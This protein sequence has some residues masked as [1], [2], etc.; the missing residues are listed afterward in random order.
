MTEY[1]TI[2]DAAAA[3]RSGEVTSVELV[4][5]AGTVS[6]ALD[7]KLGMF[8]KRFQDT[9][10]AAATEV[11]K[12]LAAGEAVGPLAGIPLGIKDIIMTTEA[13]ATAQSLVLDPAWSEGDAVVV[14]RLRAAGGIV[15]GKLT[16]CEFA[17]GM[18]DE[19][20]PFPIPRNPW[21]LDRWAGGSSSGSGSSVAVGSVLGALGTDTGGSIRLPAAYCGITGL[22]Q[23]FGRVPK[24]GCAPLGYTLDHIGPMARSAR[25]C[26]LMLGVIAG[27]APGDPTVIDVPVPDYLA[28]LTGDLT[29]V[30]IGVDRLSRFS[31]AVE[32]PALHNLI[33]EAVVALRSRGATVIDVELPLYQEMCLACWPIMLGEAVAYHSPDLQGR[34]SDYFA[35]TRAILGTGVLYSAAD[36]VQAQRVRTVGVKKVAEL[37]QEVDLVITPTSSAV[38]PTFDEL[39]PAME[40]TG[41][42]DFGGIH[43]PY[44]DTAG[45][46]VLSVPIGFGVSGAPLAMQIVGRPF[47][48]ALVLRA[49]DAFQQVTDWHL[50]VPP[51]VAEVLAA[52]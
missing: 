12:R 52:A 6:D 15:T 17:I 45:N 24:S 32:D 23:T 51:I 5:R 41:S 40:G 37:Y 48:E 3:L 19:A 14:Q 39:K 46:P 26:A 8:L 28:G 25:D 43:T 13:P 11:D 20:K 1:L 22:M 36:Y 38:A 4:D 21:G 30:K 10:L 2:T 31:G 47:D 9:A 33:D 50:T 49:G 35:G 18:P 16:T 34:W 27:Y 44:W 7:E 42:L 29:G